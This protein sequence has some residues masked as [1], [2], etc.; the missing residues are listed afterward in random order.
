MRVR[1]WELMPCT[2]RNAAYI[3][4]D[5]AILSGVP[6]IAGRE[7]RKQQ[8]KMCARREGGMCICALG[9]RGTC[10]AE[11]GRT[12]EGHRTGNERRSTT[13]QGAH[14]EGGEIVK[15]YHTT[16]RGAAKAIL[17]AGF[18]DGPSSYKVRNKQETASLNGVWFA[19]RPVGVREGAKDDPMLGAPV[20]VIDLDEAAIALYERSTY[21]EAPR[22]WCIPA[23]LANGHLLGVIHEPLNDEPGE[24]WWDVLEPAR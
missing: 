2:R 3:V 19:D 1:K 12:R 13:H 18:R 16:T 21:A 23:V 22:E 5:E 8:A 20:L 10:V 9:V 6:I 7:A 15:L 11:V 14:A 17:R 4:K 24:A